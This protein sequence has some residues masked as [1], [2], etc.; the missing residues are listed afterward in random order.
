L[1]QYRQQPNLNSV[2]DE[3]HESKEKDIVVT[4]EKIR[5]KNGHNNRQKNKEDESSIIVHSVAVFINQIIVVNLASAH[6]H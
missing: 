6:D 4:D 1:V 3:I 5:H 2:D